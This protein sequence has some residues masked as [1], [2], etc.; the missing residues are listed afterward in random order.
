VEHLEIAYAPVEFTRAL[1]ESAALYIGYR[2]HRY[3]RFHTFS[4]FQL[5]WIDTA[6]SVKA[7][8]HRSEQVK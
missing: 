2:G 5:F 7:P 4:K 8:A 1:P 3:Q 6:E